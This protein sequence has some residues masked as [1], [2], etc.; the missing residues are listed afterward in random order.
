MTRPSCQEHAAEALALLPRAHTAQRCRVSCGQASGCRTGIATADGLPLRRLCVG[1]LRRCTAWYPPA[2]STT[3]PLPP[4]EEQVD[5]RDM[6]RALAIE[7]MLQRSSKAAAAARRWSRE[8]HGLK[9]R[10]DEAVRK[11]FEQRRLTDSAPHCRR[12]LG[13]GAAI[14]RPPSLPIATAVRPHAAKAV[15]PTPAPLLPSPSSGA[16]PLFQLSSTHE[17]G[18]ARP[19]QPNPPAATKL[20][21][22][23]P[24]ADPTGKMDLSMA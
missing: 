11:V 20:G 18:R 8:I 5:S 3:W 10:Q 13:N 17:A 9:A 21:A 24:P 12:N 14:N 23:P 19:L 6:G 16:A 2:F 15:R 7:Q 1:R 4:P 22:A